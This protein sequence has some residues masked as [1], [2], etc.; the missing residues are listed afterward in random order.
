M[1]LMSCNWSRVLQDLGMKP[2]SHNPEESS[3]GQLAIVS[4][5]DIIAENSYKAAMALIDIT[6][7]QRD[8]WSEAEAEAIREFFEGKVRL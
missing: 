7:H 5:Q 6:K 4:E 2:V 8:Q 1:N 3:E